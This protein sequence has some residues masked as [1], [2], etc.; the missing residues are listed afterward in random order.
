VSMPV[1]LNIGL[2]RNNPEVLIQVSMLRS[3][4]VVVAPSSLFIP[5]WLS[6]VQACDRPILLSRLVADLGKNVSRAR[7]N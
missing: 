1:V 4:N 6:Y 5:L 2:V 7:I 3:Q